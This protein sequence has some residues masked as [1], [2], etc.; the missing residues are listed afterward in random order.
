MSIKIE[1]KWIDV[2]GDI[3]D[4]VSNIDFFLVLTKLVWLQIYITE[5]WQQVGGLHTYY[6]F[7]PQFLPLFKWLDADI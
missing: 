3:Y 2:A 4:T 1:N 7:T 6:I 5:T